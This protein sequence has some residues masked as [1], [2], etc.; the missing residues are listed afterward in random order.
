MV[1]E[2]N[3]TDGGFQPLSPMPLS[4]TPL[5]EKP[6][7]RIQCPRMISS[8]EILFRQTL[9]RGAATIGIPLTEA[10]IAQCVLYTTLLLQTNQHTNLTRIVEPGEVAIKHFVDSLT[11]FRAVPDLKQGASVIDVGTG[12][13]FPGIVLKI[14]RPDLSLTLLDSLAKRL[15]FLREVAE[16]LEWKD[17][18]FVHARAEEAGQETDHR[19]RY[20]LVTARAVASLPTL[21]EWCT[22]LCAVRGH[23]VAMK[24]SGAEEELSLAENAA[25]ELGV[26]LVND[27]ALTLPAISE[28]EAE[29]VASRRLLVYRKLSRTRAAYPRRTAEIKAKPL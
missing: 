1:R 7:T 2:P 15:T 28:D 18:F 5:S 10:Q 6:L 20:D 22:P 14:V 23:F 16:V 8:D 9:E 3:R 25:R 11:V 21:L 4:S 26:Q 29:S 13:G 27:L 24:A 12:A 17:V 19:E